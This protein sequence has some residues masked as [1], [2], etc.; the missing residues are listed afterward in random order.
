MSASIEVENRNEEL[1]NEGLDGLIIERFSD[2]L[3]SEEVERVYGPVRYDDPVEHK[4]WSKIYTTVKEAVVEE[5]TKNEFKNV[6]LQ[7]P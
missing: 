7:L 5:L 6:R 2:H 4:K 1:L 3:A